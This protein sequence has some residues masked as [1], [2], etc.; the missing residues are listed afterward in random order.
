[1]CLRF[2]TGHITPENVDFCSRN[3]CIY[4]FLL[5]SRYFK[6]LNNKTWE[7]IEVRRYKEKLWRKKNERDSLEILDE[8]INS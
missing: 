7:G 2:A 3:F 8:I 5:F 6:P 1:M 4:L